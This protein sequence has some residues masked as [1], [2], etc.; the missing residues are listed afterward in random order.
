MLWKKTSIVMYVFFIS[1]IW[2]FG[3]V[4][5]VDKVFDIFSSEEIETLKKGS[6]IITK[7]KQKY[8]DTEIAKVVGV[9]LIKKNVNAV[10]QTLLDWE[11]MP[12]Y[13]DSL[14]YYKTIHKIKH[15]ISVIEGQIHITFVKLLYTLLV[16]S[17]K[18]TYYQSWRL[19]NEQDI[20]QYNLKD[21]VKPASSGIQKIEGYQYC[22]PYDK[23]STILYYAPVVV[24]S[25]PV[26]GFVENTLA[27]KSIKDYLYGIKRY[28]EQG[29]MM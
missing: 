6:V 13:V 23:D 16:I 20:K 25:V 12:N 14:D 3:T 28:L 18:E 11:A 19:I 9:I 5:A 29:K 4:Y 8:G 7:Q 22:I 2:S 10:W 1:F 27:N 26:P 15:N 17:N 24:V 21:M